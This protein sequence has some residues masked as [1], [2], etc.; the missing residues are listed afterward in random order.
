MSNL[1]V[2]IY[3]FYLN[4]STRASNYSTNTAWLYEDDG[5]QAIQC[6]E[7]RCNERP[8]SAENYIRWDK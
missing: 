8:R 4:M 3:C 6:R 1:I 5:P 2:V 7:M